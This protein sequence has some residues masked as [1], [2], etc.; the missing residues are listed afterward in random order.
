VKRN[1]CPLHY[2]DKRFESPKARP[3]AEPVFRIVANLTVRARKIFVTGCKPGHSTAREKESHM[4][5][6]PNTVPQMKLACEKQTLQVVE[7]KPVSARQRIR[8]ILLKIF[9]GHQDFLGRTPD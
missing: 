9:E 5:A 8:E 6:N 1:R 7:S 4:A 3:V 2:S